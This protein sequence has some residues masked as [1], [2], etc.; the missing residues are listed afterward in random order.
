MTKNDA[1]QRLYFEVTQCLALLLR[2]IAH[3]RLRIFYIF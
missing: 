1:R 2:K 3:L